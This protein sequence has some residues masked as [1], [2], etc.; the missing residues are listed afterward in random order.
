MFTQTRRENST[1]VICSVFVGCL[2][3][4]STVVTVLYFTVLKEN[5][6]DS[7]A[8]NTSV[9]WNSTTVATTNPSAWSGW[10]MCS[11][12]CSSS[13]NSDR[14]ECPTKKRYRTN[15]HRKETDIAVC[16]C[17]QCQFRYSQY[18]DRCIGRQNCTKESVRYCQMVT[19]S[20]YVLHDSRN[21]NIHVKA[22]YKC[23]K[24]WKDTLYSPWNSFCGKTCEQCIGFG[25][26]R[27][28]HCW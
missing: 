13:L 20:G 3:A 1:K 27:F 10:S 14:L 17:V 12:E 28:S 23:E 19:P 11:A 2:L 24:S 9:A 26:E 21:E 22:L 18:E 15:Q 7:S 6:Q 16:N 5:E 25:A 4:L 8:T